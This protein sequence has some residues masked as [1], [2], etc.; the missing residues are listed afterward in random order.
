MDG[1]DRVPVASRDFR[2]II[3]EPLQQVEAG[4]RDP[5]AP[6]NAEII[7][8]LVLP[9]RGSFQPF[10]RGHGNTFCCFLVIMNEIG[11]LKGLSQQF[12]LQ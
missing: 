7:Q 8:P 12:V 3:D 6:T 9:V 10:Q 4:E 11:E 5:I 1:Q 2:L